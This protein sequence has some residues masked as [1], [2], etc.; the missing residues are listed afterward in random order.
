MSKRVRIFL[1][2]VAVGVVAGV[3]VLIWPSGPKDPTPK[4]SFTL[5]GYTNFA[6]GRSNAREICAVVTVVNRGDCPVT[7]SAYAISPDMRIGNPANSFTP[8]G[9]NLTVGSSCNISP[10]LCWV[11]ESL[12]AT[13]YFFRITG[14][15]QLHC[16]M[17]PQTVS[18]K[19]RKRLK[20]VPLIGPHIGPPS[21]CT[22]TSDWFNSP[23]PY[24]MHL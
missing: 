23:L 11:E 12:S 3:V 13:R 22:V 14:R 1:G 15:W 20:R 21:S 9:T 19:L 24:D 8:L 2:A 4:L 7:V 18:N 6:V 10:A 5:S 17:E 16:L